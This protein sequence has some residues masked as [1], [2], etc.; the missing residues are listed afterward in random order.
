MSAIKSIVIDTCRRLE[1]CIFPYVATCRCRQARLSLNVAHPVYLA[2]SIS[3][4]V[5]RL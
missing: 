3:L 2:S 1:Q 4:L 5:L